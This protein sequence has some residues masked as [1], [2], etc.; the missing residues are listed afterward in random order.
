TRWVS[1]PINENTKVDPSG[2]VREYLPFKSVAVPIAPPPIETV[3]PGIGAPLLSI[4]VP[5]TVTSTV[6]SFSSWLTFDFLLTPLR[7]RG[8]EVANDV[9]K[10]SNDWLFTCIL[11]GRVSS[12]IL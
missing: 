2:T 11:T 8:W 9:R 1:K 3:T 10:A 4:T 12:S 6:T 7:E 5:L